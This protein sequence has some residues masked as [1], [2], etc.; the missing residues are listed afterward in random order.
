M[1][2]DISSGILCVFFSFNDEADWRAVCNDFIT[3]TAHYMPSYSKRLKTHLVQ[4]LVSRIVDF[5]PTQ[6][7]N[8]E[9]LKLMS[10][11]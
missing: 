1:F 9:R 10:F 11:F 7:Y 6:C 4:H 2:I 3:S 5:G 8:T